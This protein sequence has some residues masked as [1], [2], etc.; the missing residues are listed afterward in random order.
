M[1]SDEE[2]ERVK[3]FCSLLRLKKLSNLN[4]LYNFQDTTILCEIFKNRAEENDRRIPLQS[5]KVHVDKFAE[6]LDPSIFVQSAYFTLNRGRICGNA[7]ESTY[8]WIQFRQYSL[9]V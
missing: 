9:G 4:D 3:K 8:W 5:T 6:W 1:I 2:Y 7:R